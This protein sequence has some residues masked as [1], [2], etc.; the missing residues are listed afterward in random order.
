MCYWERNIVYIILIT[1]KYSS[2]ML[3]IYHADNK[4]STAVC[5]LALHLCDVIHDSTNT[6]R[7]DSLGNKD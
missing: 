4:K 2:E 7:D 5:Y 1:K 6:R 3:Y